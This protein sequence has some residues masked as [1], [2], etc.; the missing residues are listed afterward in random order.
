MIELNKIYNMD[1]IKGMEMIP[2]NAIDLIITSP[3]YWVNKKYEVGITFE[4]HCNLIKNLFVQVGRILKDNGR[5]VLNYDD[6]TTYG[7]RISGFPYEKIMSGLYENFAHQNNLYVRN[8]RIWVKDPT[9]MTNPY[10]SGKS[11]RSLA[12][13]EYLITYAKPKTKGKRRVDLNDYKKWFA[14]GVWNIPSVRKNNDHP[15]KFPEEIPRRYILMHTDENDI[16]LDP[17][18]G[19]GTTAIVAKE[20]NR[21]YIGFEISKEYCEIAEKRL[22][23]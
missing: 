15:A 16:V 23:I 19:S 20:L 1:C 21:N 9:W 13:F 7:S 3:P 14:R 18:M 11:D 12:E 4:D 5:F 6:I 8:R 17:F 10:V 2:T 22:A